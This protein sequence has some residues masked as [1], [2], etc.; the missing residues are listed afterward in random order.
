VLVI[1]DD[2]D[3]ALG[4]ELVLTR[5]GHRV[6]VAHDGREGLRS[7]F[8]EHAEVVVL[9]VEMPVMDGWETLG[10]LR[11]LSDVPVLMLTAHGLVNERVRGLRAGADDYQTKPFSN[12]ELL[13]RVDA[14]LRRRIDPEAPAETY[15][16]E[17][18]LIDMRNWEVCVN[19]RAVELTPLEF[20]LLRVFVTHPQQ[21]LSNNQLIELAW[22][23]E[24]AV[25]ATTV[26]T[27][28]RYLRRKLGW[29]SDDSGPIA[30]V[31]GVGYRYRSR[32]DTAEAGSS[33]PLSRSA[34]V[35]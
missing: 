6:S 25:D 21:V 29:G 4:L 27:Y 17:N 23:N 13:A 5:A 9:D 15:A 1:E 11:E 2:E 7:F 18:V 28:V 30:S 24:G 26:K 16:D 22:G 33:A 14:L 35:S 20:R 32:A 12:Q 3:V 10:R 34:D 19:G 8:N 31:R